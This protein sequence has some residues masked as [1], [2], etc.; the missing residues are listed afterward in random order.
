MDLSS[1]RACETPCLS[2]STITAVSSSDSL[3]HARGQ[4][5]NTGFIS[6][7]EVRALG[8]FVWLL[9]EHRLRD[10]CKAPAMQARLPRPGLGSQPAASS[11]TLR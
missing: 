5:R 6:S 2:R 11:L 8:R 10:R 3:G 4:E 7:N 1:T 9:R